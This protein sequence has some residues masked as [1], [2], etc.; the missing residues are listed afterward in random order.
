MTYK[1][2]AYELDR[3]QFELRKNGAPVAVEPQVLTLLLLLVENAH[4]VVTRD[5]IIQT[6]WNG[7]FISE[8]AVA[9][10]ISQARSTLGDDG[11]KQLFI[12]TI[13]RRG[14]RFVAD[15]AE[16]SIEPEFQKNIDLATGLWAKPAQDAPRLVVIPF[17]DFT[18]EPASDFFAETLTEE[19]TTALSRCSDITVIAKTSAFAIGGT[20]VQLEEISER[21]GLKY[22]VEGSVQ[23]STETIRVNYR[24]IDLR[25]GEYLWTDRFEGSA[26]TSFEIQDSVARSIA[27]ALPTRIHGEIASRNTDATSTKLNLFQNYLR[28]VWPL[29]QGKTA[30]NVA[31]DLEKLIEKHGDFALAHAHL[32][33]LLGYAGFEDA[34][35]DEEIISKTAKHALHAISLS[36]DDERVVAKAALGLALSGDCRRAL[37]F[38]QSALEINP[39][40]TEAIHTRG[41]IQCAAGEHETALD[42]HRTAMR[43][44]PLCPSYYLEG[45]IEACFLLGRY[46][47]AIAAFEQWDK[48]S[49]HVLAYMAACYAL[50]GD[51]EKAC[52]HALEFNR[53]RPSKFDFCSFLAVVDRFFQKEQDRDH[54]KAGFH[55]ARVLERQL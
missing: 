1:F 49:L 54:W 15:L 34:R 26:L 31:I 42:F 40:S 10:R 6:V 39:Y 51:D 19:I 4:R 48:P 23:K 35:H 55:K 33:V 45:V 18:T 16:G 5:E 28:L 25:S 44:D 22:A 47:D 8:A 7:R 11:K 50:S 32:S 27:A 41:L 43:L 52:Q 24:I 13:H 12:K 46:D 36:N 9:S 3:E 14:L 2:G 29:R 21:L 30:A 37:Q 53:S 20:D 17:R 38:S